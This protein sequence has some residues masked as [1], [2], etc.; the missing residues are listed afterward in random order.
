MN[1]QLTFVVSWGGMPNL[2]SYAVPVFFVYGDRE[3]RGKLDRIATA[4]AALP[5]AE[6]TVLEGRD[7]VTTAANAKFREA[8][9]KFV[10]EHR[11]GGGA[12]AGI[13][14]QKVNLEATSE[15]SPGVMEPSAE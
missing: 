13:Q 2:I 1:A 12:T 6:V 14:V 9:L 8:L 4:V 11:E 3:S 7:H 15:P 5:Q 10:R